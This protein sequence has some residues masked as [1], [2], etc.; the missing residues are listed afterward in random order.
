VAQGEGLSS[1]PRVKKKKCQGKFE[2]AEIK[3]S[4]LK[5]KKHPGTLT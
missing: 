2:E 5:E 4:N 3:I 1:S